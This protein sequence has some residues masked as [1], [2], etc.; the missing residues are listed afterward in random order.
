MC[1]I[2]FATKIK[3]QSQNYKKERSDIS[4][5]LN[6]INNILSEKLS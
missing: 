2:E 4:D 3:S 5:D 1:L 6:Q